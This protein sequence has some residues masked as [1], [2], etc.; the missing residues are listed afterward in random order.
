MLAW[1]KFNLPGKE[2][3][4]AIAKNGSSACAEGLDVPDF[5]G[6]G[7]VGFLMVIKCKFHP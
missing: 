7:T 2:P 3:G 4:F 5:L 1:K 6:K